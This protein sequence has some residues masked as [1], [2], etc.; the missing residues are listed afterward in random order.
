MR[1][2]LCNGNIV[3]K[4]GDLPFESKTLGRLSI[5]DISFEECQSCGDKLLSP[6]DSDKVVKYVRQK[7]QEAIENMPIGD[8]IPANEAAKM[9]GITKQAF[10]KR[11]KIKRGLIFSVAK[12]T[13]KLFLK[14]SVELFKKKGNGKF[15]L[16][17]K[18]GYYRL[19]STPTAQNYIVL[20]DIGKENI[21]EDDFLIDPWKIDPYSHGVSTKRPRYYH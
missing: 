15:L 6:Q 16:S 7:E 9:L 21:V 12:G 10:S 20:L 19:E 18:E 2:A 5:P 4:T 1:C 13:R 11:P 3:N 8:F 14:K 17:Q